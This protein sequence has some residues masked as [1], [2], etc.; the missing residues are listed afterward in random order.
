MVS[1][2]I[3][4]HSAALAKGVKELALEMAK[5]IKITAVGGTSD[6]LLGTDYGKI[7][8]AMSEIYTSEGVIVLFDL[9]SS[10]MTAELAKEALEKE[11]KPNIYIA[12]A[13]L[14]EG[15]V[16]AAVQIS[17][18]KGIAEVLESLQEVR[19]NKV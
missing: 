5:G 14:V 17:I 8:S 4:S 6:G 15:V 18:G 13:A 11:G 7:Y 3:L 12:D 9:G 19:L 10:Y 16:T 1:L 2:L